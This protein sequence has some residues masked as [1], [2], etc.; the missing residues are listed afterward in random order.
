MDSIRAPLREAITDKDPFPYYESIREEARVVW[1]QD[2]HG[3]LLAGYA[4]CVSVLSDEDLFAMPVN[5]FPG[6]SRIRGDRNILALSGTAQR[7]LHKALERRLAPKAVS[8]VRETVIRPVIHRLVEDLADRGRMEVAN[9][10]ATWVPVS[11]IAALLDLPWRDR[12]FLE[13]CISWMEHTL[14]WNATLGRD[15][16]VRQAAEEAV[17]KLEEI[18]TPIVVERELPRPGDMIGE[19][20]VAG[21]E[22]FPDWTASDVVAQCKLIFEAGADTTAH[23]ICSL[24][25]IILKN[26]DLRDRVGSE[27]EP[28]VSKILEEVL[29]VYPPVQVRWRIAQQEVTIAGSVIKKGEWV[30]PLIAAGNRDA[31]RY[32][33]PAAFNLERGNLR[34]HLTFGTGPRQCPGRGLARMEAIEAVNSVLEL[35]NVRLDPDADP[36]G[37]PGFHIRSFRPL[38][39]VFDRR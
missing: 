33:N 11:V 8:K 27:G 5:K 18:L 25:Y 14:K 37:Y 28:A 21:R 10:F 2:S 31:F 13:T 20:W 23:L 30:Y 3:W 26:H 1:D 35:P 24:T 39:V 29:R 15:D 38:H 16:K 36:P 19:I 4:D 9:D 6:T 34:N 22:V 32:A 7:H 17:E 12:I